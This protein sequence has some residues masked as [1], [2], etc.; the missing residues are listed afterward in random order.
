MVPERKDSHELAAARS[1]ALMPPGKLC[2]GELHGRWRAGAEPEGDLRETSMVAVRIDAHLLQM[3]AELQLVIAPQ[4][5][6]D[7]AVMVRPAVASLRLTRHRT[8]GNQR[9][10]IDRRA[11]TFPCS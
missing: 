10:R 2:G 7:V 4:P 9:E 8:I 3:S 6:P 5:R 1:A 11:V